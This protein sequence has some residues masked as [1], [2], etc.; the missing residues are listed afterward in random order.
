M[1]NLP[2]W[3]GVLIMVSFIGLCTG[4]LIWIY[5]HDRENKK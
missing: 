1:N 3:A 4:S 2:I 5:K